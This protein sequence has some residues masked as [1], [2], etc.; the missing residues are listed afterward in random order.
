MASDFFARLVERTLGPG[1]AVRPRLDHAFVPSTAPPDPPG[2]ARGI[3]L[4]P[5]AVDRRSTAPPL[6]AVLSVPIQ[7]ESDERQV[8]AAAPPE[9]SPPTRPGRSERQRP[10]TPVSVGPSAA[11]RGADVAAPPSDGVTSVVQEIEEFGARPGAMQEPR[12]ALGR[13]RVPSS[14]R[15]P[16]GDDGAAVMTLRPLLPSDRPAEHLKGRREP[17]TEAPGDEPSP[18]PPVVHV[19]I[20]R[21]EVRAAAPPVRP[22]RAE[23]GLMSLKDYLRH[24][25]PGRR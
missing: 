22:R 5:R 7:A 2:P 10:A 24:D 12:R 11:D 21:I 16:A 17:A 9:A 23:S 1:G 20:G 19:D 6:D 18:E 4:P 13:V 3:G 15:E 8:G 14:H 25:E